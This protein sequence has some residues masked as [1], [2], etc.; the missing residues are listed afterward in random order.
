MKSTAAPITIGL[1][2]LVELVLEP[3]P[4]LDAVVDE[5]LLEEPHPAITAAATS[6]TAWVLP[7]AAS[8]IAVRE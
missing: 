3:L 6:P 4:E 8:L 2:E 1:P 7:P 5:L